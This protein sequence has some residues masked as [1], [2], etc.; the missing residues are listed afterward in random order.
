LGP[1]SSGGGLSGIGGELD[2]R[3]MSDTDAPASIHKVSGRTVLG[4]SGGHT[5]QLHV[6]KHRGAKYGNL[7]AELALAG[8]GRVQPLREG[9]V[10]RCR[11]GLRTD[12]PRGSIRRSHLYSF[13]TNLNWPT[14]CCAEWQHGPGLPSWQ[15]SA[16]APARC[17]LRSRLRAHRV[18][19]LVAL[20]VSH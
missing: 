15:R 10:R 11:L 13:S 9:H 19:Y 2:S 14:R 17:L 8:L 1:S 6:L 7:R 5:T 4:Q 20:T 18:E 16:S 3:L 12:Q